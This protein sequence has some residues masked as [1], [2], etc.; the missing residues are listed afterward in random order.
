[1][2]LTAGVG[3]ITLSYMFLPFC[4]FSLCTLDTNCWHTGFAVGF[5]VAS[6]GLISV[7]H[8]WEAVWTDRCRWTVNTTLVHRLSGVHFGRDWDF[9]VGCNSGLGMGWVGTIF[10]SPILH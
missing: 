7:A 2:F 8:G 9:V 6:G 5:G 10:S 3:S 4:P 1:M